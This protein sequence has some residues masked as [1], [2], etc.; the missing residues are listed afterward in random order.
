M[1]KRILSFGVFSGFLIASVC[2]QAQSGAP[3][4]QWP[5]Y[6][7]DTANTKYAPLDQIT[8]DNV[9]Q[10]EVAWRWDSIENAMIAEE[11]K[12][13]P[14]AHEATP[15]MVNNKL[16]TITSHSIALALDPAT[17]EE[18]WRHDPDSYQKGRP[19]NLGY[20][21]RGLAYW[22][23]G[24]DKRVYI[25]TGDSRIVCLNA[26]TGERVLSFG[27]NGEID[28]TKQLRREIQ[29]WYYSIN[30]PPIIC[31]GTLV[32]G[33]IIFDGA[34][35]Q[36]MPPGDVRGWD[37]RT[38]ELKWTFVSVPQKGEFGNETW[39]NASWEYSGNT[40]V[41]TIMSADPELGYVYLPF[42]TPTND[43]YGG[44]RHGDNLFGE[45]LV[46]VDAETGERVWHFQHVHHG[47]WDYDLPAAPALVDV[48][49]DGKP[50]KILAQVTKQGF[51][52]VLDRVTGEPV[53]PIEEKP[54]PQ[55]TAEG[56]KSSPTQP[57]PSKP[58]PYA[59]QGV[60]EDDLIDF[61]P[62]IKE[63]AKGILAEYNYGP[64][65]TPPMEGKPTLYVPGWQGAANWNGVSV[66][67][68]TG[69]L[70]IP[71]KKSAISVEL[72][73]PDPSRSDFTFVGNTKM[74]VNGPGGLPLW[75]PPYGYV[76]ALDLSTGEYT[77]QSTLGEG[78]VDHPM[79]KG[80][81]LPKLGD[82][83]KGFPLLT[84]T[85]L[86]IGMES[87]ASRLYA[88]DKATGEE[89]WSMAVD[90]P[91]TGAPMTYMHGGK[92]YIVL[93]IGGFRHKIELVALALS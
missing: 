50:R 49:I 25:P 3:D 59:Q 79:L 66:D 80:L 20:L 27:D 44:H 37:V 84:K 76:K 32:T 62:E 81:E 11:R 73:R 70:Y 39:E 46:C 83:G 7:G 12:L 28:L 4:G 34:T 48:N 88:L 2:V 67:P 86:F 42:G 92:Q 52:W 31:K 85:L 5:A 35:T 15:L 58:A 54:V 82:D 69:M 26:D 8:K 77:W 33:C 75:K 71:V 38:G 6:G 36:E 55:S 60:T 51:C 89:I 29:S 74:N 45:T 64:L 21:Q 22:E 87:K 61:T 65:Y 19:T 93:A 78:P 43:W 17:G 57:F 30:S 1:V 72:V 56:E 63:L 47:V 14:F 53:W 90:S 9:S 24:D 16:Y 13:T 41:W 10:L 91:V 40:N 68:E 23:D 18:I